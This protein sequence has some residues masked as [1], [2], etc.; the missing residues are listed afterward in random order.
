MFNS[1]KG[2]SNRNEKKSASP[3]IRREIEASWTNRA[4]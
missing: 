2:D 4:Q 3:I 1:N